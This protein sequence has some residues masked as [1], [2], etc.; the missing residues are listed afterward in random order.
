MKTENDL[1]D[2]LRHLVHAPSQSFHEEAAAAWVGWWLDHQGIPYKTPKGNIVVAAAEPDPAK[3]TLALMAHLD[4]VPPAAGYTRDPYDPG[5]DPAVIHGL[6]SND[7]GGSVVSM[8]AVLKLFYGKELPIN[9]LLLLAR[10]EECSGPDGTRWLFG[11]EG[12]F[13]QALD[14]PDWL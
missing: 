1:T 10:E 7:D 9:L 5:T 3:K 14:S 2:L 11:P 6:G 13:A 8:L 4:T 12:P